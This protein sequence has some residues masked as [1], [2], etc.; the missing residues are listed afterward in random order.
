MVDDLD[1]K[2]YNTYEGEA[3]MTLEAMATKYFE[4]HPDYNEKY[5]INISEKGIVHTGD[6]IAGIL[7]DKLDGNDPRQIALKFH[8]SLSDVVRKFLITFDIQKVVFSGG[9]FQNS[10]LVDI[11]CKSLSDKYSVYFHRELSP[12]DECIPF[13]Q[14]IAY[15]ML[16]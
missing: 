8:L 11:I 3:A 1:I 9:V 7:T 5:D 6:L 4:S 14:L 16:S 15:Q 12:N 2:D 13:G 10:L